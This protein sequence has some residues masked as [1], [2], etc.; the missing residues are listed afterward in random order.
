MTTELELKAIKAVKD[1]LTI[2]LEDYSIA[3]ELESC[4]D[5]GDDSFRMTFNVGKKW[6]N[7]E[8]ELRDK[9]KPLDEIDE[10]DAIIKVEIGEDSWY[11]TRSYD[12][13]VKYFWMVL[14]RWDDL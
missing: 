8:V 13:Q 4:E 9:D 11:E 10:T 1:F 6:V 3:H 7:F 5:Q 2:E 14:L 12:W